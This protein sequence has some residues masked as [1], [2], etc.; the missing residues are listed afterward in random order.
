MTY[1]ARRWRGAPAAS[2]VGCAGLAG[3]GRLTCRLGGTRWRAGLLLVGLLLFDVAT[4]V[5]G[6]IFQLNNGGRLEGTLLNPDQSPRTT[7]RIQLPEGE[8][9]LP[10]EAV[11]E[12]V[13]KSEWVV[14]YERF[15][16]Q[17]PNTVE[18]HWDMAERC[19]Q[20]PE[21]KSQRFYHLE[22][23][24]KLDPEHERARYGLG[25]SRLDGVW[26]RQDEWNRLQ[27]LVFYK[28]DWWLRQE[29]EAELKRERRG[30]EEIDWKK[31]IVQWRTAI[32][33]GRR[34]ASDAID[35]LRAIRDPRAA[36][37]L[38]ER[39]NAKKEPSQ[40]RELYI[41][42]LGQLPGR[43]STIA[44]MTFYMDEPDQQLRD[45]AMDAILKVGPSLA[46]GY[47]VNR[48][49]DD[50]NRM[51]NRAAE[52]LARIRDP[53]TL[54]PLIEALTTKHKFVRSGPG[55]SAG[56]DNQGGGGLSTGGRPKI[57]LREF[58]NKSVLNALTAV[59]PEG[60]NFGYAKEGW[61]QWYIESN[62]PREVPLR[63]L[64]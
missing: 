5:R 25:Y 41:E 64:D 48:L 34:G 12:V 59:S 27:G 45:R 28:G 1:L 8:L 39:L 51:V 20:V 47:F 63:R 21:L 19:R 2:R 52:G 29:L 62:T 4:V 15:L 30:E 38:A 43:T 54:L 31:R 42:V 13:R 22:Q 50:D 55:I 17:V 61:R 56:F 36:P 10:V 14:K 60:V 26:R 23:I 58:T 33:R 49:K 11:H 24:L 46:A 44:L 9:V 3:S 53:S 35:E 6:E 37:A 18:G 57:E 7:Y 32:V 16:P 40:L